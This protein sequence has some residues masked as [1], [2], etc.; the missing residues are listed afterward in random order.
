MKKSITIKDIAREAKVSVA[1]VSHVINNSKNVSNATRQRVEAIIKK[2]NYI[3]N[4]AARNLRQQSTRTVAL[5]VSSFLDSFVTEMIYGIE[6]RAKELN[7][8]VLLVITN[9][10]YEYEKSTIEL[11]FAQHVDGIILSPTSGDIDYLKEYL[12]QNSSMVMVNR[13]LPELENLPYVVGD[14]YQIGYDMTNHLIQHKHNRIGFIYS[15]PNVST[16]EDRLKGYKDA[17]YDNGIQ[18]DPNLIVQGFATADGGNDATELLL[19]QNV[20]AIASQND[21]MTIGAITQLNEKGL[22]IPDDIALIGFGD[23]SAAH[24][25]NPPITTITLPGKI[26]G[27]TAFDLLLNKI[28]NPNYNGKVTLPSSLVLRES[29]GCMPFM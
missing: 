1:T 8:K 9:E 29:C 14:N 10:D 19:N 25:I 2:Y 3:P 11:L 7:Y 21:L 5:V 6:E 28:N 18:Y 26:I 13:Y 17:L 12:D 4:S 22:L 15:Y 23:F 16:T 20:S 24:I 27:R